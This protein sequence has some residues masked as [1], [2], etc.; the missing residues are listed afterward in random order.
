MPLS[1]DALVQHDRQAAVAVLILPAVQLDVP[2]YLPVEVDDGEEGRIICDAFDTL[3]DLV[4]VW[5]GVSWPGAQDVV[6]GDSRG[7]RIEVGIAEGA[8]GEAGLGEGG[9]RGGRDAHRV[10]RW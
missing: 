1:A 4:P 8:E 9:E 5:D 6:R 2:D 10:E 3:G 7:E